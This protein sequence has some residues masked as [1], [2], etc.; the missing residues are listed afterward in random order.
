MTMRRWFIITGEYPP[1]PG[2]ISDYTRGVAA[3]LV[4]AG[5]EVQIWTGPLPAGIAPVPDADGVAVHRT[6]DHFG[7]RARAGIARAWNALPAGTR[8]LLQYEPWSFGFK[9]VNLPFAWWVHRQCA[10]RADVPMDVMFHEVA[11]GGPK[12]KEYVHGRLT[13]LMAAWV[14]RAARRVFMSVTVW[15]P[16]LRP[17]L[18]QEQRPVWL[19]VPSNVPRAV[20][21]GGQDGHPGAA[22]EALRARLFSAAGVEEKEGLLLGHFST[23]RGEIPKML[24]AMLPTLLANPAMVLLLL[25]R[26][27]AAFAAAA[28]EIEPS[29]K[30]RMIA[31]G[32]LTLEEIAAYLAACDLMVQP[33]SDG[34]SSRRTTAMAGLNQGCPIVTNTGHC[35]DPGVW[36]ASKAV[37]LVDSVDPAH[38]AAAAVELMDRPDER[39]ILRKRAREFYDER[40]SVSQT[41]KIL[42]NERGC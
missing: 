32:E 42:R 19:P 33:Y 22:S 23:F 11:T 3:A 13:I 26:G 21:V 12:L 35:S 29:M 31:A 18:R 2:G 36:Q 39:A 41:V 7:R 37:R 10:R 9:G 5:D 34:I 6:S 30:R 20:E 14:A 24:R 16:V 27:G 25:G 8:V 1:Q 28:V 38:I 4:A 40:F 15:E 17:L